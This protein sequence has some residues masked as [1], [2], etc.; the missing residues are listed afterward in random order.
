MVLF[1]ALLPLSPDLAPW[2]GYACSIK[3]WDNEGARTAVGPWW[4]KANSWDV[5]PAFCHQDHTRGYK[6]P[7]LSHV[8]PNPGISL[9]GNHQT[10]FLSLVSSSTKL[11]H[12]LAEFQLNNVFVVIIYT[13]LVRIFPSS[14]Y[15]FIPKINLKPHLDVTWLRPHSTK[16]R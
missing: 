8:N 12:F 4:T 9:G 13:V 7:S 16:Y 10:S 5:E 2:V 11:R 3:H 6:P 14:T 15:L 1:S